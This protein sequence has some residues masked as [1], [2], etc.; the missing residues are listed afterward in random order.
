MFSDS[1]NKKTI[2]FDFQMNRIR[3]Y[4]SGQLDRVHENYIFQRQ[5]LRKFSA[6]NYLRMRATGKSTQRT[7][8]K[9]IE[10]LPPLYLDLSN[11]RQGMGGRQESMH[12][13]DDFNIG[14]LEPFDPAQFDLDM[15]PPLPPP[16]PQPHL[17]FLR[18]GRNRSA[19]ELD[20]MVTHDTTS[21][22]YFTP[23][24]TPQREVNGTV[25]RK[26]SS[27][28]STPTREAVAAEPYRAVY[29][30]HRKSKSFGS[31]LPQKWFFS[32]PPAE[33]QQHQ[34]DPV[35]VSAPTGGHQRTV[36]AIIE[37]VASSAAGAAG[38]GAAM[39]SGSSDYLDEGCNI[40]AVEVRD[41]TARPIPPPPEDEND[42]STPLARDPERVLSREEPEEEEEEVLTVTVDRSPVDAADI[43]VCV[44]VDRVEDEDGAE[45]EALLANKTA[46]AKE[47][48]SAVEIEEA[49]RKDG[50]GATATATGKGNGDAVGL[51][52]LARQ[53]EED[54]VDCLV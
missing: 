54:E 29:K 9:V 8:N 47:S 6:Q 26:T 28:K 14:E 15:P 43:V 34:V 41:R 46:A 48:D 20:E 17:H 51:A 4:S 50:G 52:P 32:P 24:A 53:E 40:Q 38:R 36:R 10:N 18:R 12:F 31:F 23:R 1:H 19:E 22:L 42:E 3:D 33:Q 44:D 21:S 16:Q 30:T 35:A 13:P 45:T 37:H 7:L 39:V 11:C 5:R 49:F 2:C 25:A 27:L